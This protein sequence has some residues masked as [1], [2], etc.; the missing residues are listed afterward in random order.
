[1]PKILPEQAR[2][3]SAETNAKSKEIDGCDEPA[4]P[5]TTEASLL[6]QRELKPE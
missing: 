3:T 4:N 5:R 2:R 1:M 6:R